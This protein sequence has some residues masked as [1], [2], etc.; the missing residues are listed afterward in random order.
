MLPCNRPC[1]PI[2]LLDG[3]ASKL[4][5]QSI[6]RC[7]EVVGFMCQLVTLYPKKYFWYL[8][9]LETESNPSP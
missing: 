5:R 9:L 6:H 7:G 1:R 2:G 4:S 8:F 3:E